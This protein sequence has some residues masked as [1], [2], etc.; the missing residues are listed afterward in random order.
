MDGILMEYRGAPT[1]L[2]LHGNL[3]F[4]LLICSVKHYRFL[5]LIAYIYYEKY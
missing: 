4:L 5:L 3:I 2:N 1:P